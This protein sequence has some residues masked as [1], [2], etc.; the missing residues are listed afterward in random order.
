MLQSSD[1]HDIVSL[2]VKYVDGPDV[3]AVNPLTGEKEVRLSCCRHDS[4]QREREMF[5]LS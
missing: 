5:G 3:P 4:A 2:E 1:N